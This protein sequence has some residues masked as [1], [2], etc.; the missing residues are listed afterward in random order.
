MFKN[1]NNKIN[2]IF[3]LACI[4]GFIYMISIYL[5]DAN[6][7]VVETRL[8]E[9]EGSRRRRETEDNTDPFYIKLNGQVQTSMRKKCRAY[10]TS[11]N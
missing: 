4:I 11:P 10:M 6:R 5:S 7:E 2:G 3:I 8:S 1:I 9:T